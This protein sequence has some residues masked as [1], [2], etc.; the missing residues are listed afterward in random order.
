[1]VGLTLRPTT[2]ADVAQMTHRITFE[3]SPE[4]L[5]RAI[6]LCAETEPLCCFGVTEV[7]AGV[8]VA[9]FLEQQPWTGHPLASRMARQVLRAWQGWQRDF[10]YVEA[11]VVDTR[12]DSRRL[13]EWLGFVPV[14]VKEAYGPGGE[15]MIA[16]EWR[17]SDGA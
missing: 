14:L 2:L 10:R 12:V 4:V 17:R 15:T 1:M 5:T 13:A 7:W 11:L 3:P 6:T 8:G 9:W 16:Y